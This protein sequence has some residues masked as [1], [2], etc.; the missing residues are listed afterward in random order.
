[1][2]EKIKV[3]IDREAIANELEAKAKAG[4]IT[5]EQALEIASRLNVPTRAVGQAADELK[6]K[7]SVCQLGCFK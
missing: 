6:I 5:C 3:E 4:R 1:M 7:V 2:N